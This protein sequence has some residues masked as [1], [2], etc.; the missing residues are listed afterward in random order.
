MT[1]HD[2]AITRFGQWWLR[3]QRSGYA[4]AQGAHIH[5]ASTERYRVWETRRAVIWAIGLPLVCLLVGL[6]FSPWGW[7]AWGIYLLQLLRQAAR[8]RGTLGERM[9]ESLFQILARFAE[10]W[11]V[12]RFRYDHLVG[13]Q[14]HVI[15]YK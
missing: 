12:I 3:A 15:E 6:A 11:G 9:L 14:S 7:I 4:F 13:R 2:A 1:I 5:G 10:A 8:N